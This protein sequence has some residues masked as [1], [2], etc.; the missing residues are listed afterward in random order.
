EVTITD[1]FSW[2]TFGNTPVEMQQGPR[3]GDAPPLSAVGNGFMQKVFD[4]KSEDV[5]ALLNFDRSNAYVLK[6][7]SRERTEQELRSAFLAEVNNSQAMRI[8]SAVRTQN[9]QRMLLGQIYNRVNLDRR[10]LQKYLQ[11]DADE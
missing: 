7:A 11:G 4:L 10:S 1:L 2:F 8:M 9:A 6:L 5:I 3:L